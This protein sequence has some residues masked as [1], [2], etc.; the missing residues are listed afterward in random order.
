M[1]SRNSQV[2]V[3]VLVLPQTGVSFRQ[4]PVVKNLST[5]HQDS[6]LWVTNTGTE[7]LIHESTEDI[8]TVS[9]KHLI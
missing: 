9:G 1:P 4:V 8:D 7:P 3:L 6:A 2:L 5:R